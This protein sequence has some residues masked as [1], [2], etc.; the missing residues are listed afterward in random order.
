MDQRGA[1][2]VADAADAAAELLHCAVEPIECLRRSER[3][4]VW[5]VRAQLPGLPEPQ[6]LIVKE[7]PGV[8][9]GWIRES[10]ALAAAPSDAPVPRLVAASAS[11]PVVV[12]ADAGT[13]PSAAD[14]MLHGT[15]AD[16]AAAVERLADSLA[17]LHLTTQGAR[18]E[19]GAQLAARSGGTV[20]ESAM[21]GIVADSVSALA[22]FCDHLGVA[23]PDG[24]EQAIAQLPDRLSAAG[25]AALTL[26]DACPDNNVLAGTGYVLIDFEEAEWRHVAWDV[27]Y[28]TVPWPSCWCSF[29]LPAEVTARAIER[30]R[31]GL[32][33]SL[34]YVST[35]AFDDDVALATTGWALLSASWFLRRALAD[36]QPLHD[37]VAGLPTRRA[38]ILHRLGSA[39]LDVSQPAMAELAGRLRA[40][41]VQRWG[42]VPLGLA[43]AFG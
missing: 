31:A 33:G 27:A 13:G 5:R 34:P 8:T 7:Y 3:S 4:A 12:M 30:Y 16:A 43:P 15:A 2:D 6:L 21:P 10:A 41:L 32:A 18:A 23:V 26:A 37:A 28:L 35:P 1:A 29:R 9:E 14:A 20:P 24:A 42:E 19:F 22:S 39:Q 38:I 25:P 36:D 17:L 40:E 11:P